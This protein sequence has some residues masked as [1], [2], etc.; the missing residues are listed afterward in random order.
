MTGQ[1]A[2]V[3]RTVP[4]GEKGT[5]NSPASRPASLHNAIYFSETEAS[6]KE[7]REWKVEI[8]DAR[9][10]HPSFPFLIYLVQHWSSEKIDVAVSNNMHLEQPV[11][12]PVPVMQGSQ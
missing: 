6:C 11:I 12:W 2:V 3:D 4:A 5:Q 10:T 7:K 9:L 1:T 8:L